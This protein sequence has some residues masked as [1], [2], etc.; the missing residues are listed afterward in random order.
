MHLLCTVMMNDAPVGA[1][2]IRP[3]YCIRPGDGCFPLVM[4]TV[5]NLI[6]LSYLCVVNDY[7]YGEKN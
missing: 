3:R 4:D 5:C 1:Y 2:C 7:G 6:Y